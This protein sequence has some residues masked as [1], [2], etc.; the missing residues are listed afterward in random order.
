[1]LTAA[2][3]CVISGDVGSVDLGEEDVI[4]FAVHEFC[5]A[6]LVHSQNFEKGFELTANDEVV[7][8]VLAK[9]F[10]G[11]ISFSRIAMVFVSVA[12]VMV[13]FDL[14][15]AVH[16]VLVNVI[17]LLDF[18]A[19]MQIHVLRPSLI[20]KAT[21]AGLPGENGIVVRVDDEVVGKANAQFL[22]V[23]MVLLCGNSFLDVEVINFV[24]PFLVRFGRCVSLEESVGP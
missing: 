16:V 23:A 4:D 7:K 12:N 14:D 3:C 19:M 20:D 1:M 24:G 17:G 18:R 5:V 11:G 8:H 13:I 15:V 10:N 22:V 21:D 2:S 9:A 6:S